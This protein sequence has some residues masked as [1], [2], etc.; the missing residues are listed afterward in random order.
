MKFTVGD[1]LAHVALKLVVQREKRN[2][3]CLLVPLLAFMLFAAFARRSEWLVVAGSMSSGRIA[4]K[5]A[6]YYRGTAKNRRARPARGA[7][8][9]C[10]AG[11]RPMLVIAR[12]NRKK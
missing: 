9:Q 6:I 12:R 11:T 1:Y 5:L 10:R 8:V 3:A 4:V 2:A 7:D